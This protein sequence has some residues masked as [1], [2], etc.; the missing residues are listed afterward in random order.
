MLKNKRKE[1]QQQQQQQQQQI[2]RLA[3]QAYR[4]GVDD[5]GGYVDGN[6]FP[7]SSYAHQTN[8]NDEDEEERHN[9]AV[10]MAQQ[11]FHN[12]RR[13]ELCTDFLADLSFFFG[14]TMY[15]WL[16]ISESKDILLSQVNS[17]DGDDIFATTSSTTES[18]NVID[19]NI[20]S[21]RNNSSITDSDSSVL[22]LEDQVLFS[23]RGGESEITLYILYGFSAG[24]LM[25]AAG[26]LRLFTT[27]GNATD[28]I[29]CVFMCMAA[30]FAMVSS[31]L[32]K[33]NPFWSDTCYCVSVHLFALQAATLLLWRS[34]SP[35]GVAGVPWTR[36]LGDGLFFPA[37]LGGTAL[38]YLYLFD[39][40]DQLPFAYEYLAIASYGF[41]W[42][43]SLVYVLQTMCL[44]VCRKKQTNETSD[45]ER[46]SCCNRRRRSNNDDV[47]YGEDNDE[48]SHPKSLPQKDT[49]STNEEGEEERGTSASQN[50][51]MSTRN[52]AA[53]APYDEESVVSFWTAGPG[54]ENKENITRSSLDN[55][56]GRHS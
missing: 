27:S 1:Q 30:I 31:A 26:F 20:N 42:L 14:S 2:H 22:F 48:E 36:L 13:L 35:G 19:I 49:E 52:N 8:R 24:F 44:L 55:I 43:A 3:E 18:Y 33:A 11:R 23:F 38:G 32:V 53:A 28:K 54:P 5:G 34:T 37:T 25:F 7:N 56:F 21:N 50:Q 15:L 39:A 40:T 46:G 6:G 10:A 41:W 9:I 16:V 47:S 29:P 45:G 51:G 12:S 4:Y 17:V